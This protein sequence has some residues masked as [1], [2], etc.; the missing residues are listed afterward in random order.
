[1]ENKEI[2][3]R[4]LEINKEDLLAK[5]KVLG[6]KDLGE[7]L[8][9]E[10]IFYDPKLKMLTDREFIRL[11]TSRGKTT[12]TYKHHKERTVDGATEIEF[13]VNDAKSAEAFL[14]KIGLPAYRHQE[15]KR[16]T[17]TLDGVTIDID[18]WPR[19]PTY[20]ELEGPSEQ[21]LKTVAQKIGFDWK[22]AIFDDARAII[23]ERYHIPVG[24]LHWFTFERAE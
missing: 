1:M 11:R 7:T 9:K 17:L 6:A 15:K 2:E 24:S 12:L 23:E 18:T 14:E 21:A 10:I 3:A 20:V 16:H 22:D 13:E 5:L 19:I 8:L 4:F